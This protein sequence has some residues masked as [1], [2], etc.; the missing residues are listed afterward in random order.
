MKIKNTLLNFSFSA[1]LLTVF[2]TPVLF[3]VLLISDFRSLC[4]ES[5]EQEADL[6]AHKL[7]GRE[8]DPE[9]FTPETGTITIWEKGKMPVSLNRTGS[10]PVIDVRPMPGKTWHHLDKSNGQMLLCV[11]RVTEDGRTLVLS[12]DTKIVYRKIYQTYIL[13]AGFALLTLPCGLLLLFRFA[14]QNRI[15]TARTIS[16][17]LNQP[18]TEDAPAATPET[19]DA[20]LD[21]E[22]QTLAADFQQIRRARSAEQRSNMEKVAAIATGLAHDFRNLLTVLRG[23]LELAEMFSGKAPES[24]RYLKDC[25][26][27]L[28]VTENLSNQLL[29]FAKGGA[30]ITAPV[31][32][33]SFFRSN[34]TFFLRNTET[35]AFFD[36]EPD[37]PCAVI[38]KAQIGQVLNNLLRNASIAMDRKGTVRI[39]IR[40]RTLEENN[41]EGLRPGL[42]IRIRI[43]DSGNGIPPEERE[44]IF[45]PFYTTR[46]EGTGMGLPMCLSTLKRHSG[47]I[48][49]VDPPS[50]Q[51]ACFELYLPAVL[52]TEVAENSE[53]T[54]EDIPE[55]SGGGHLLILDDQ[56]NVRL[57]LGRILSFM[58]CQCEYAE[59]A[60]E[61]LQKFRQAEKE[62]KPFDLLF[63]DLTLPDGI[64]GKEVLDILKKESPDVRAVAASGYCDDPILSNPAAY[65]FAAKL[66]KPFRLKEVNR[67]MYHLMGTRQ[68][69]G[70]KPDFLCLNKKPETTG[71]KEK[72]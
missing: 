57:L 26:Q 22:I 35:E 21:K 72:V 11:S 54:E 19:G 60:D 2:L 15:A 34:T 20:V 70:T 38:D 52:Q 59:N 55:Y 44:K 53:Q 66:L 10:H 14:I 30:P 40:S 13:L 18:G 25:K 12:R 62:G 41:L 65:G 17:L 71:G 32:T 47:S 16:Q 8:T 27:A 49:V 46:P 29:S 4:R 6:I 63:L 28:D 51:G 64:G 39:Q 23:N 31:D 37:L 3:A 9:L 58:N 50:G 5:V 7:K 1:V 48:Q 43:T 42:Y 24:L 33:D 61:C 67:V 36:F 56:E 68:Q 45:Y 69:N